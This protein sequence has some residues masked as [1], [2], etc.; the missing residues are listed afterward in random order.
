MKKQVLIF[1]FLS[2]CVL[3]FGQNIQVQGLVTSADDGLPLPGVTVSQKG[4]SIATATDAEGKYSLSV[5]SSGILVFS[6][7]GTKTQE[8]AFKQSATIN[9]IMAPDAKMLDE[10]VAI[11]YGSMKKSDLTGSVATISSDQL[12]KTPSANLDQALQGRAAG[13]TVNANSG[14]P[15]AAAEVRIRGIG[16]V[17]NSA[18]IYV[19]DGIILTDISFLNPNDIESTEV[20]KDASSTAI[21]GSRGANGVI[22][23]TTK[24]GNVNGKSE[25]SFNTYIGWQ[26][27][28]HK[29]D[30]MKR[31]EFV[32]TIIGM[33]DPNDHSTGKYS[34]EWNY[35]QKNGFN[36]WLSAYRLGS[37]THYPV[38]LSTKYPTGFDYSS[39]DTDWQ[40]A[41]FKKNAL[42]QNYHV[43]I[44]GNTGKSNYSFSGSYFNQDGTIIGSNF[45][46]FT[47][48][49]NTSFQ[50]RKWLKIGEDLTLATSEGRNAMN[51]NSS[52]GASILSAAI[53][54]APWDPVRYP[55]GTHNKSGDDFGGRISTP[56]NFKNVVNP[57]S[58]VENSHPSDKTER[59][60]GDLYLEITPFKGLNFRS[61]V[62]WDISNTRHVLFKPAYELSNYDKVTENYLERNMGRYSTLIFENILT[63]AHKIKQHDFSIMVGQTTEEYNSYLIS[64][65]GS[66]IVNADEDHWYLNQTTDNR[67]YASDQVGRE[68]RF[69][70]L[71]RLQYSFKDRYL[72]TMNFRADGTNKFPENTWG[73]FPS[74]ALGWK[75]SEENWM[76]NI[77][78]LD[79]MKIR[80]GWGRI[81]NDKIGND[82]FSQTV[83]N[84]GPTFVDYVLGST[85]TLVNGATV[86]TY[87]NNGGKWELTETI[88]AGVDFGFF[89]GLL[90]GNIDLFRRDTKDML[91]TVKGPAYV[92]NRYD[93][94]KNV[95]TVR[96]QGIEITLGHNHKL[97]S[98]DYSVNGN[99]SFISNKLTALNGGDKQY[100]NG[101]L[102]IN[103]QNYALYTLWGYK[104]E[105]I[106]KT[107]QEANDYYT[108]YT[109]DT[110]PY[111]AGDAKYADISKDG[112]LGDDDKTDIG[113]PFPWLTYGLN[114]GA[115]W[116]GLDVQLFFQGVYGNKIYNQMRTRTEGK[117]LEATLSTKMRDVWTVNN[118]SGTIPYAYGNSNNYA[119]SSRFVESGAY[120]RL[121][122][123]QIG[124]SLP[125]GFISKVG[126]QKCRFYISGSNLFTI[127]GY[128]GYDPEVGGG[129]DYGNYPQSR[130]VMVG[131]NLSF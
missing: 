45:K 111:H 54:M 109:S 16:T 61:D 35:F 30:L 64:G 42:I 50:V 89:H 56:S 108:G 124:Y 71:G 38:V 31:D 41:V 57:I 114:L 72:L 90:S 70:L 123:L 62:S 75:I 51:N 73:Y 47:L 125:L 55:Q 93:A 92:G 88:N 69:S 59:W 24:K 115:N 105:G 25:I 20:L 18:P 37:D 28:W 53:A 81:G 126:I 116:K 14:Q 10:V 52:P 86:L 29:L 95:G 87:I 2:L 7:V 8:K 99:V 98:V 26:S 122:N 12:K 1:F 5:P 34:S 60:V 119:A 49:A 130:T 4:T 33:S 32:N 48:R 3:T 36:A 106:F 84:S 85:Q 17:N 96:N 129:I 112:K 128:T 44:D 68:R 82:A 67:G 80:V 40:Q 117:G 83:F 76:K 103:D 94:Q 77:S 118:T 127:T 113:N 11:G 13:V 102:T 63:Y 9:V 101:G 97:G 6:F 23:V 110:N 43:S 21:Y 39:V 46:R 121:K 107:D 78:W 120:L 74:L 91:L 131:A 22:L 15:G 79:F 100:G 66:N 19:V 27:S 65:S 104:Y 58:M